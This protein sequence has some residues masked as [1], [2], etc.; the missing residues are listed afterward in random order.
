MLTMHDFPHLRH[1]GNI[2]TLITNTEQC[3]S[4]VTTTLKE[5]AG[6]HINEI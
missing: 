1:P 3:K 6:N 5:T 2:E 4:E